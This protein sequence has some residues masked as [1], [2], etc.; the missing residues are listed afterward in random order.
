MASH[1]RERVV[2]AVAAEIRAHV[3]RNPTAGDTARGVSQWWLTSSRDGADLGAVEAALN[4]LAERGELGVRVLGSGERFYFGRFR[5]R[6][7]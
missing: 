5:D 1:D 7:D 4:A 2:A 6:E 3:R